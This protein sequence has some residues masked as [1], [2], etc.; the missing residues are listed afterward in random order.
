MQKL[1]QLGQMLSI[2]LLI[3][4]EPRPGPKKI[5]RNV[6]INKS[7]LRVLACVSAFNI[8]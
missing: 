3:L 1:S 5:A 7:T 6:H 4:L 2:Q 8:K